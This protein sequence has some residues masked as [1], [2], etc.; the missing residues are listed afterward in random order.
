MPLNSK[1]NFAGLELVAKRSRFTLFFGQNYG[2]LCR[3]KLLLAPTIAFSAVFEA[4]GQ[5]GIDSLRKSAI[6]GDVAR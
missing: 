5:R 3:T 2:W 1:I 6:A 4:F